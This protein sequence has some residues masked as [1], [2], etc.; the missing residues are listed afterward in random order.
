[1][2]EPFYLKYVI[3]EANK[4]GKKMIIILASICWIDCGGFERADKPGIVLPVSFP[5]KLAFPHSSYI[6]TKPPYFFIFTTS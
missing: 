6:S 5:D 1:M 4:D 3:K 2:K